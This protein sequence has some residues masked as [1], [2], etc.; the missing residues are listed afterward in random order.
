[1]AE[2][3]KKLAQ[4]GVS[5][6]YSLEK[7]RN[8]FANSGWGEAYLDSIPLYYNEFKKKKSRWNWLKGRWGFS[9]EA[10]GYSVFIGVC[11]SRD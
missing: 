7:I 9:F 4:I 6:G 2:D 1:M 3:L 10:N 5:K 11:F 8:D